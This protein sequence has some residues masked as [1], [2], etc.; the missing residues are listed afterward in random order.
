MVTFLT[1]SSC[2]RFLSGL[3]VE[4]INESFLLRFR[5]YVRALLLS[6]LQ[7]LVLVVLN[8]VDSFFFQVDGYPRAIGAYHTSGFRRFLG[9]LLHFA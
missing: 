9:V 7:G 5:R 3:T 2:L 1:I 8:E 6:F 4:R